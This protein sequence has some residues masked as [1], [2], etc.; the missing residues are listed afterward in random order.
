MPRYINKEEFFAWVKE[1]W[2]SDCQ[3]DNGLRCRAC[4]IDDAIDIV[5]EAPEADVVEVVRCKDCRYS[6]DCET[7]GFYCEHPDNRNPIECRPTD[8]CS[9]G[10]RKEQE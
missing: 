2:C 6:V 1:R 7:A 9:D 8:Y 3:N 10:E 4:W 5:E